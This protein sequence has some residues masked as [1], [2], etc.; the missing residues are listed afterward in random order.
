M[1]TREKIKRRNVRVKPETPTYKGLKDDPSL[2]GTYEKPGEDEGNSGGS[3]PQKGSV[4]S[5]KEAVESNQ[6]DSE[7]EKGDEEENE[8][9]PEPGTSSQNLNPPSARGTPG[10]RSPS[11]ETETRPAS[12]ASARKSPLP[13]LNKNV[14]QPIDD[15]QASQ[16]GSMVSM[17][18]SH[19]AKDAWIDENEEPI[20]RPSSGGATESRPQSAASQRHTK[21]PGPSII[22]VSEAK[23]ENRIGDIGGDNAD[24]QSI[25]SRTS[26]PMLAPPELHGEQQAYIPYLQAR[27]CIAKIVD[28][29][30]KMKGSHILIVQQIQD[31]YKDIEN[32][33]QGQFNLFVLN[34]RHQ[35]A[36]K[37]STFRHVIN[38]H[39]EELSQKQL[40]WDSM[41]ASLS[42]RNNELLRDKRALLIKNKIEVDQLEKEKDEITVEFTHKLDEAGIALSKANKTLEDERV[43]FAE[44]EKKY[45]EEIEA[46]KKMH[47]EEMH[48]VLAQKDEEFSKKYEELRLKEEEERKVL[49][50]ALQH[51][52]DKVTKLEEE[53]KKM[54][55][56]L[57]NARAQAAAA[58]V[59]IVATTI[60]EEEHKTMAVHVESKPATDTV[61]TSAPVPSAVTATKVVVKDMSEEERLRM[62]EER[63]K[64]AEERNK[65]AEE[66]ER[67]NK[68]R[69]EFQE[70]RKKF[71]EERN[72]LVQDLTNVQR[73]LLEVQAKY[74]S[75]KAQLGDVAELRANYEALQTQFTVVAA[76]VTVSS[77]EDKKKAEENIKKVESERIIMMEES[78]NLENDIKKWEEDFK[79]QNGREP[80]EEDRTDSIKEF[81]VMK[82]ETDGMVHKLDTKITTLEQ[83]KEGKVP[84]APKVEPKP[85]TVVEPEIKTVEIKVQDPEVVAELEKT[86]AELADLHKQIA[87]LQET[88][89]KLQGEIS[90]LQ[91]EVLAKSASLSTVEAEKSG[92]LE[93]LKAALAAAAV[94]GAVTAE[95]SAGST[96]SGGIDA[97][98][99]AQLKADLE[100]NIKELEKQLKE[101][102]KEHD[103]QMKE[104]EREKKTMER[105]MKKVIKAMAKQEAGKK[106]DQDSQNLKLLLKAVV[107]EAKLVH[108]EVSAAAKKVETN[109]GAAEKE[110][111]K[112]MT[113]Y[114]KC[115]QNT[116]AWAKKYTEKNGKA[117]EEAD[118]DAD[119]QKLFAE[120]EKSGEEVTK[121]ELKLTALA[122]LKTG[123]IPE[124]WKPA[125]AM[126]GSSATGVGKE[127][128]EK[129]EQQISELEDKISEL[130]SDNDTLKEKVSSLE[131]ED[132]EKAE[133]I[134]QLEKE[135]AAAKAAVTVTAGLPTTVTVD[136]PAA[137]TVT[138]M[139]KTDTVEVDLDTE[140][141]DAELQNAQMSE[142]Q[143]QL[144]KAEAA[145]REEQ[146]AHENTREELEALKLQIANL[147][148]ETEIQKSESDLKLKGALESLQEELKAKE[149]SLAESKTRA[150]E[151]ERVQ[152]ANVPINTANE[153][154]KL[155]TKI[156]ALEKERDGKAK[157]ATASKHKVAELEGKASN[158][159]K[160]LESQ[161]AAVEQSEAKFKQI[162]AEKDAQTKKL[163]EQFE[164]KEQKR[165]AEEKTKIAA[166]QKKIRALEA[167]GA[168]G[169]AGAG[170]GRPERGKAGDGK[171][172]AMLKKLQEQ[173]AAVKKESAEKDNKLK[174]MEAEMKKVKADANSA[175][176]KAKQQKHEKILKELEKKMEME[177]QKSAKQAENL[178]TQEEELKQLKKDN[179]NKSNEI[180]KLQAEMEQLGVAASDGIKALARVEE[181]EKEVKRLQEE[182]HVLTENFNSER[183]LRKKYYNMVEDM[184]GKIRVYA[185]ARPM[186]KSELDRGNV[187]VLKSPDEY[188][189]QV[190]SKRGLKEFQFDQIFM[191][192]HSQ[193]KVFEDTHNLVQSAADGYNVCIFA[194]G[195]T[196]SGKTYTMIGDSEQKSPGIAPRAFE[197]IFELLEENKSKF[198]FKVSVYMLELYNDQLLDLF[199]KKSEADVKMEIKKDKKGMVFV[200]GA[201]V[202]DAHNAKE[203]MALFDAGSKSRH[204]ASTSMN[205]ESSRSHLVVGVIIESTNRT[206]GTVTRGKLS[207]VDLAGSERVAK[208]NASAEQLKEAN[209]I[210][211]SLSAL[212]DVISA[213]SSEQSFIPYRNN[214]LTMLMQDSLG[215]N[216]KTLMFVNVSPADYNVDE[217]VISLTYASRVK[218]IT[219]SA[220]K[221]A[222]N[223][224]INRLK[225]VIAKLK[226][227]EEVD[228]DV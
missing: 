218:L 8:K 11:L 5:V 160:S 188:T 77:E 197:R 41:L 124:K 19:T 90:G 161:K 148:E 221:N 194:Y 42:K 193:E 166:L 2:P 173:Y 27:N 34:L 141:V 73:E 89:S 220:S 154:K 162:K 178:K 76:A 180:K 21:S 204:V 109:H 33:T 47:G 118:R 206:S 187:L 55:E 45:L 183:V 143:A 59:A 60:K 226:A 64:M 222:D 28:D 6:I 58:G 30:K 7:K 186:S 15:E 153:I 9:T 43:Q 131:E 152:L 190:D 164:A 225:Q 94:S 91:A 151:L 10:K 203:L 106:S 116:E 181:L 12:V 120:L 147:R 205:A 132:K 53:L 127:E 111:P 93:Q 99:H 13:F 119:A 228:E 44:K 37:V 171:S 168:A 68:E 88:N 70:D 80:K 179:D 144:D 110:T 4:I 54:H 104:K 207:L 175:Q 172:E 130:E 82:E 126:M 1:A 191:P 217:T 177:K 135:L 200:Q 81:Y 3:V 227:G 35:Y 25:T 69:E 78:K 100:N 20:V 71:H 26:S 215:G 182:N 189:V 156:A 112:V 128:L 169:A 108:A 136:Q 51:E 57:E 22:S 125:A 211:K 212:G 138:T 62:E 142:L 86:Q 79:Q 56:E 107:D 24:T 195:Q 63:N 97:T 150:D 103:H 96:S 61:V 75:L 139:Q 133:T 223:K 216:A 29:M 159:Q 210:N 98:V 219:N 102:E 32:E 174:Q 149:K 85:V 155:K 87:A 115:K 196:G 213:L 92:L 50:E 38:V 39:R 113:K 31:A 65:M 84:E 137:V 129:L 146:A 48:V 14:V 163:S 134:Q 157:E 192:E 176:D 67:A 123:V 145:L 40:Y 140:Q 121:A 23:A 224:E 16:M 167:A 66:R 185:R 52:K 170:A 18:S 74:D 101:K 122:M 214:K 17:K 83:L 117:P 114:D 46:L 36:E 165:A 202:K 95:V 199:G 208:T 198:L 72:K 201:E 158:L 49:N 184:K 105:D 209:S